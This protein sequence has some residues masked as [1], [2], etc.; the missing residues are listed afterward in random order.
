MET[1]LCLCGWNHL[2]NKEMNHKKVLMLFGSLHYLYHFSLVICL[3]LLAAANVSQNT[4]YRVCFRKERTRHVWCIKKLINE[5]SLILNWFIY[6][7]CAWECKQEL[8]KKFF[9][10]TKTTIINLFIRIW[11][12]CV[13]HSCGMNN[14][15]M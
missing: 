1:D 14:L 2:S 3:L 4:H 12:L 6:T 13:R 5:N 8:K 7:S 11:W 9:W 10:I 15:K